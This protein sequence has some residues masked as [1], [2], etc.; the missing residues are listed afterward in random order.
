MATLKSANARGL[1]A[2]QAC[3]VNEYLIDLNAT[4][5]A[6]RAGYSP[7]TADVIGGQLLRKTLVAQAVTA[8]QQ[9][10]AARTEVTQ[11]KVLR[12]LA[13]I[14][15]ADI[16]K[17]V[18]WGATELRVAGADA[19]GAVEVHHGLALIGADEIDDETA[20]AI[21]EISEGREGLKV[22]LHDKRAA[23]VD[24]GRHLGMFKDKVEHSGPDGQPL[25]APVLN[26]IIDG[27]RQDAPAAPPAG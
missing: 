8:A 10:R 26:V 2:K 11:D 22:K 6:I 18:R 4:Q 3:F 27:E 12:E 16:R 25:A 17:V 24:I 5:A 15:F 23:L 7:R 9:A 19:D 13:R 21:S 14:G 20:A 1:T